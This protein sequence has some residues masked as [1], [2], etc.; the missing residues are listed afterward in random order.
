[1]KRNVLLVLVV[2]MLALAG[3]GEPAD[4]NSSDAGTDD[5]TAAQMAKIAPDLLDELEVFGSVDIIVQ[6]DPQVIYSESIGKSAQNLEIDPAVIWKARREGAVIWKLTPEQAVIWK[7]STDKAVIWKF[8]ER[9]ADKGI[10]PVDVFDSIH[11]VTMHADLALVRELARLNQTFYMTP[12]RD[13]EISGYDTNR[14]TLGTYEVTT[15]TS[16]SSFTGYTGDG[17]GIAIVDS[18]LNLSHPDFAGR[19]VARRNFSGQGFL[20][21]VSDGYG[22]GTHVAGLAAGDGYASS[23]DGYTTKFEGVAPEANLIIAKVLT[24]AGSGSTSAVVSALQWLVAVKNQYNIRVINLSLGLPAFDPYSLDPMCQAV[25]NAVASGIVVVTAAGNYGYYN[26]EF[27]YG[28]IASPGISPAAITVGASNTHNTLER[29]LDVNG[30][31]D[32]VAFFSSRGPTAWDGVTKPDLIAP[33]VGLISVLAPGSTLATT[34]PNMVIDPCTYGGTQCGASNADYFMMTGTSMSTPLVAG[35][36]ALML[37]ANPSLTTGAVKAILQSTAEPLFTD[38]SPASCYTDPS[39]RD[40]PDCRVVE[41]MGQGSGLANLPGAVDLSIAVSQATYNMQPGEPWVEDAGLLPMSHFAVTGDDVIWGQGL[42]WTGKG[43]IGCD[44]WETFQA[45]FQPGEI[46]AAGLTWTGK[47]IAV[48]EVVWN[49]NVLPTWSSSFVSPYSLAG[50]N[51]VLGGYSY[52]W[53]E[54]PEYSAANDDW[55]PES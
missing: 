31:N 13:V 46:W 7:L 37:E 33:G 38:T 35:M 10:E 51:S 44:I 26:G 17:I 3:C 36:V 34:Y 27:L 23:V 41:E 5:L 8:V 14:G 15:R 28:A 43:I 19:V 40:T 47:G 39:W 49:P 1:M 2:F 24:S 25:A 54:E 4:D 50:D 29:Q 30:N 53:E 45:A 20:F 48:T 6:A 16:H 22:H 21:N 9:L 11:G 52:D 12:D 32:T 18:G 55:F 42:T